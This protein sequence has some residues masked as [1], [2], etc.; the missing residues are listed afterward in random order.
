MSAYLLLGPEAGAKEG[1]LKEIR[2]SLRKAHSEVELIRF[3]P[4]ECEGGEISQAL[5]NTTLFSDHRLVLLS[6]AESAN[7]ALIDEVATYLAHPTEGSTLV[8][9]SSELY[10]SNKIS[11]LIPKER[12]F[13]FYDLLEQQKG[14]WIYSY[15][16]THGITIT[17]DAIDLLID[18]SEDNTQ[19]L[20]TICSQLVLFWQLGDRGTVIEEEDVDTYVFHSRQEDAFTLFPLIA[21]RDLKQSLASLAM[22]LGSGE[23][24]TPMLLLRGLLWQFRRLL[25]IQEAREA[26]EGE[27][28]AFAQASVLGKGNAIRRPKDITTYRDALRNY[29]LAETQAIIAALITSDITIKESSAELT[30]GHF[31]LLLYQIIVKRGSSLNQADPLAL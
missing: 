3:Y 2:D 22:I 1:K 31:E 28:N 29:S 8:I 23:S 10:I 30:K 16:R 15:F 11:S 13:T 5:L 12:T 27:R 25:S 19:Q 4:F 26:G 7:A 6:Q 14:E 21:R 9:I 17:D 18:I 24:A 20:R